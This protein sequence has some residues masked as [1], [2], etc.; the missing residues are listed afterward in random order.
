MNKNYLSD[1]FSKKLGMT[2]THYKNTVRIR[3][4]KQMIDQ[5][6]RSL[7]EVATAVGFDSS[8]RFSKVFRQLEGISPQQYRNGKSRSIKE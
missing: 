2:F 7:T 6:T 1:L 3:K 8:S 5:G 4:A